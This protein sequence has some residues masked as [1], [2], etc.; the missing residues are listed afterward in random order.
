MEEKTTM[1]DKIFDFAK[2]CDALGQLSTSLIELESS[3]KIK[4]SQLTAEKKKSASILAEKEL[5]ITELKNITQV[6]LNKIENIN[7]YIDEV[8]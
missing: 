4:N 6:A 5:K 8:L 2:T 1:E 7:S 3:V